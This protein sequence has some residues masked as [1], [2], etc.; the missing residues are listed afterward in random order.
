MDVQSVILAST[1]L[2]N[3]RKTNSSAHNL[4]A[5][6]KLLFLLTL[7]DLPS[8]EIWFKSCNKMF[9]PYVLNI[10]I[11]K[12][13][14]IAKRT[15]NWCALNVPGIINL[16]QTKSRKSPMIS[17]LSNLVFLRCISTIFAC[18]CLRKRSFKANF[19]QEKNPLYQIK[20][21]MA[22]FQHKIW[23]SNLLMTKQR[24]NE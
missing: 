3:L 17:W 7:R 20:C 19:S 24:P 16:I 8:V 9:Q 22:F 13:Y 18:N 11:R 12:W 14:S 4:V 10:M 5:K 23:S 1:Y 15:S 21:L 6:M 2:Y